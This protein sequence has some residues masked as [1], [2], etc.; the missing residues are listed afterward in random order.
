MHHVQSTFFQGGI[1]KTLKEWAKEMFRFLEWLLVL[2]SVK[3]KERKLQENSY[4]CIFV[5]KQKNYRKF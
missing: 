5:M 1:K 4:T 3:E 2:F